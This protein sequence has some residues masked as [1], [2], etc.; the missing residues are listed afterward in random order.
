MPD[1]IPETITDDQKRFFASGRTLD[2]SFRVD[3][4][5]NFRDAIQHY[6]DKIA[7]ALWSDMHKSFE[8]AFLTEIRLVVNEIDYHLKNLRQ[9]IKPE[10]TYTPLFLKPSSGKIIHEPLGVS[11][12]IS[13]WNYPFQLSMNPLVG[14][15]S[16]GC[17]A[18]LKPSPETPAVSEVLE[19]MIRETF[20]PEYIT[21]VR[22]GRET[23]Q[24]LL[25]KPFDMIFFTGSQSTGKAIMKAAAEHLT[26]VILELGGKNPCI[27][28]RDANIAVAA[29]RIA[30]GKTVNA[31][32]TCIA[33]DYLLIHESLQDEFVERFADSIEQMFGDRI[34]DSRYYSRII[35]RRAMHRLADLIDGGTVL[36]GGDIDFEDQFIEPTIIGNLDPE[37]PAMHEEVF[38]PILPLLT[39]SRIEEA[40]AFI[41]KKEKP[42]AFY[43][44]GKNREARRVLKS[45]TSGG[46]CI[47]D[48]L[49]QLGNPRLPFGGVGSSGTGRY[50]GYE[51]F[52]AFSNRRSVVHTPD[53]IDLSF[54]YPP[55]RFFDWIK[56]IY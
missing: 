25:Q 39:F 33:P 31:G 32:Q 11:L 23:G 47:N 50:R 14:A 15:I 44:F 7:N 41:N 55:Y 56:K 3:Q 42:L 38:G 8:E 54:R 24:A 51:S 45:T 34:S 6:Q 48:T 18:V 43:Y 21:L 13:P 17:C 49:V 40:T 36:Y 1:Y 30:W 52:K 2:F 28:D 12:I 22:G 9:W 4:L 27:V 29:R 10:K 35:H 37:H 16:A 26:P 46:G 5:T 19:S 20:E 53:W